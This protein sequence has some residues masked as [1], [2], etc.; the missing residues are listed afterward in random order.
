MKKILV[1]LFFLLSLTSFPVSAQNWYYVGQSP[2]DEQVFINN[3]AVVKNDVQA[4]IAIKTN[5]SAAG[6]KIDSDCQYDI[7]IYTMTRNYYYSIDGIYLYNSSHKLIRRQDKATGQHP[8]PANSMLER[9]Y[10]M[11]W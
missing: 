9:I 11:I 1:F 10:K 3:S 4:V 7:T 6:R 8:I 2:N 5:P